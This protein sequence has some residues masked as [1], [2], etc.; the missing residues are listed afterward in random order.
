MKIAAHVK[1]AYGP[2]LPDL[3]RARFGTAHRGIRAAAG[4]IALCVAVVALVLVLRG[5]PA[6]IN[7][8]AGVVR[9]SF[10]Y[11][12]LRRERAPAGD[13]LALARY[14]GS[15][16][17]AEI[18]VA[19]LRLPASAAQAT[20]V[21]PLVA[22]N[23]MRTLAAHTPAVVLQNTGPTIVNGLAGY[24]FTYKRRIGDDEYFG[25]VIFLT[26]ADR[27]A[28]VIVSL[29]AQPVLSGIIGGTAS[30]LAGA[31]YEPGQGGVGVLFQ[32]AGL[33][34][35]PLATLRIAG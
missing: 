30:D 16:L 32:P 20:G 22:A 4:L 13:A 23:Y 19:P 33:L 7:A 21:E 28:G 9:F 12:G 10:K 14:Q 26:P 29:L 3:A 17:V 27:R 1:S 5:G 15:R 25:R 31:L 24:N 11:A 18:A 35:E 34:S 8:S 6:T 2:T